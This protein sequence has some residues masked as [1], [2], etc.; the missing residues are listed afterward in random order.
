[1]KEKDNFEAFTNRRNKQKSNGKKRNQR[2]TRS[3]R[4][5]NKMFLKGEYNYG[6]EN[7]TNNQ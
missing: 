6:Y 3:E 7:D 1:M 5:K 4:Y 2:D